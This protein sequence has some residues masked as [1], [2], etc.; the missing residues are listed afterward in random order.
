MRILYILLLLQ[1]ALAAVLC[2]GDI[3]F[4][5]PGKYGLEFN[6]GVTL[7]LF[8]V[9]A[10]LLGF[11]VATKLRRFWWLGVQ[12]L[13]ILCVGGYFLL[14]APHFDAS[15]Y[16]F[17]VG[18]SKAELDRAIGSPRGALTGF[19]GKPGLPNEGFINLRGMTVFISSNGTVVRVES[20]TR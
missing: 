15:R 14:P 9:V 3:G 5:K 11:V 16:Q 20:N 8:Y 4:D 13:P 2:F 17:L 7:L 12:L 18:K 19:Q 6:A 1:A 10:L